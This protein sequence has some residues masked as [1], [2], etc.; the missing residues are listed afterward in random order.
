MSNILVTK[1]RDDVDAALQQHIFNKR[2]RL[3]PNL[4]HEVDIY[5][6]SEALEYSKDIDTLSW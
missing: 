1:I 2:Q 5:L 4:E 3:M 6:R